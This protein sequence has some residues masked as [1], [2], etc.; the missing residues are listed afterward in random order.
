MTSTDTTQDAAR[1][2]PETVTVEVIIEETITYT[3][4][5][6]IDPADFFETTG[7]ELIRATGDQIRDYSIDAGISHEELRG[8]RRRPGVERPDRLRPH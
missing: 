7:V 1:T 2:D 8:G 4:R 6:E 5:L 3:G